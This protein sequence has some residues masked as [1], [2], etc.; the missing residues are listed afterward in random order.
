MIL[1]SFEEFNESRGINDWIK[2]YSV[3]IYENT[4][5][6]KSN[7]LQIDIITNDINIIDLQIELIRSNKNH[8]LFNPNNS[9][10]INNELHFSKIVVEYKIDDR[11]TIIDILNHELIHLYE[12]YMINMKIS[13]FL[14]HKSPKYLMLK[15]YQKSYTKNNEEF[16]K[17]VYLIYLSLDSEMNARVAEIYNYLLSFKETNYN[18]LFDK[19]QLHKNYKYYLMLSEFDHDKF[20]TSNLDKIGLDELLSLS[21]NIIDYIKS[22]TNK[23]LFLINT[24]KKLKDLTDLKLFYKK[25]QNYFK[26][27]SEKNIKK[28]RKMIYEV[29]IDIDNI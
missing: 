19:L 13:N 15:N 7:Q 22:D 27:K 3:F 10:I 26:N 8:G 4:L 6:I 18:Y 9:K 17:F 12:Y 5:A 14:Y 29:I 23:K 2:A 25:W 1:K 11:N 24:N 20:I 28:L 16:D 21:N